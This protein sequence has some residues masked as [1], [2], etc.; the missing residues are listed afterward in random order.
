MT[1]RSKVVAALAACVLAA[2]GGCLAPT[3]D[4]EHALATDVVEVPGTFQK[5]YLLTAGDELDVMVRGAPE[6]SRHVL[7]R[8]DGYLSL[9]LLGDVKAAGQSVPQLTEDLTAR[10]SHRL[11]D[12]EVS[13]VATKVRE[14]MVFVVGEVATPQPVPYR[15]A[16]TAAQA[17]SYAGGLTPSAAREAVVIIRLGET[18]SLRACQVRWQAGGQPAPYMALQATALQPDDIVVVPETYIAQ[19]DRWV[20]EYVNQPLQGVSSVLNPIANWLLIEE[21]IEDND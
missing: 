15:M 11:T 12:P 20:S 17:V 16:R 21:L 13:V 5:I 19:F 4:R 7:I 6:V 2:L 3:T 8:P 10:F 9:P 14:P 1:L 18:G